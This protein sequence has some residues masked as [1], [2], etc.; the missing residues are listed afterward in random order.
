MK[1]KTINLAKRVIK[2]ELIS[3]S[4]YLF[5]GATLASV[6]SF[7]F[8]LFLVRNLS[9]IDYGIYAALL[10][11][12]TLETIPAQSL[13]AIIVRF[14]VDYI[15]KDEMGKAANL[16]FKM[17]KGF[18]LISLLILVLS[19]VLSGILSNF[20]KIDNVYY[21]WIVGLVVSISY[22]SIVNLAFLQSLLKFRYISS[23]LAIGAFSRLLIG[24][25][26]VLAG[27][28]IWGALGAAVFS[29]GIPF[30]LGFRPLAF[31][32]K[33][34]KSN[35]IIVPT[36]EIIK[37]AVPTS[38]SVLALVS[39]TSTDVILV[40]HFLSPYQA[41]LYGGL[42]LIGKVIFYFTGP[43]SSVMFPLVA[44]RYTQNV[45][46]SNLFYLALVIILLPSIAITAFYF[47]FPSLTIRLFLGGGEYLN[48]LPYVGL[49]GIFFTLFSVLNI[50]LNFFLSIRKTYVAYFTVAA[51]ALQIIL[52]NFFHSDIF[53]VIYSSLFSTGLLLIVFTVLYLRIFL[54]NTSRKQI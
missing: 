38:I 39:L 30:I 3:G 44:K 27:L 9:P 36:G 11:F 21:I 24:S 14:A 19:I 18:I 32:I 29:M 31:L 46:F 23:L 4:F 40:K 25:I 15:A 54:A 12:I 37:Y 34:R 47:T 28:K 53:Q 35:E 45:P 43:I 22:L 49:F 52:I 41:G 7:I 2:S 26:L 51:A 42:S 33:K 6:I 16:Y 8:N 1:T 17:F 5:I 10:S 20:L 48:L 50:F 13:T